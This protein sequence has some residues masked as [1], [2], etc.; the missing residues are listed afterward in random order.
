[1]VLFKTKIKNDAIL[2]NYYVNYKPL[3]VCFSKLNL[4]MSDYCC[5]GSSLGFSGE[6]V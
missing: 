6:S 3:L 4:Q 5:W 2:C 1:M